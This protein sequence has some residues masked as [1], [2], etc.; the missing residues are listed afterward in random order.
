[1]IWSYSPEREIEFNYSEAIFKDTMVFFYLRK[2]TF[3][4]NT[5]SNLNGVRIG[6]TSSYNYGKE[7]NDAEKSGEINV[8]WVPSDKMNFD[9]L[10]AGRIDVFPWELSSGHAFLKK[11]IKEQQALLV[12]HHPR[13]LKEDTYHLLLSLIH[14]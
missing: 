6:A 12:T 10:I 11:H 1:M 14:I 13:S 2:K 8:Q 5:I 4:W 7:F 9:K 3:D